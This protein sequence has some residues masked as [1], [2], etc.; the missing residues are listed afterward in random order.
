[1][2]NEVLLCRCCD[3]GHH[4]KS[5]RQCDATM[6]LF[7]DRVYDVDENSK[8]YELINLHLQ[9]GFGMEVVEDFL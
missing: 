5:V 7:T 6:Y 8:V 1:M 2:A 3:F 4:N 9:L